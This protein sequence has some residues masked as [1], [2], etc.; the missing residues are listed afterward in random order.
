MQHQC[1]YHF[2]TRNNDKWK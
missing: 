2:I 1:L